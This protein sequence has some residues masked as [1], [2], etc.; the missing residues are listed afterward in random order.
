[1]NTIR[2]LDLKHTEMLAAINQPLL[3]WYRQQ[4]RI[5][6][7]RENPTPYRV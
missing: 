5:L 1:M 6:P 2:S 4:A 3:Q 7:W